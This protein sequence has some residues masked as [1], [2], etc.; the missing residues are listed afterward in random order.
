MLELECDLG[1]LLRQ[2]GA[3]AIIDYWSLD[4]EGSELA[5]LQEFPFDRFT[6]RVLT[7]EHNR[8]PRLREAY[9]RF[10]ES[11]GF[12]RYCEIEIDDCYVNTAL[13]LTA[14]DATRALF[15]SR[16]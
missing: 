9:R 15:R 16:A 14:G 4:T 8:H 7:V 3:P 13:G 2:A 6:F 1:S 10:L 11:R 5:L 12:A